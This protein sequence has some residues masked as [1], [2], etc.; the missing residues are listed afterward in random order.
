MC[1]NLPCRYAGWC[2]IELYAS[3]RDFL[4][5]PISFLH[6][7]DGAEVIHRAASPYLFLFYNCL[8]VAKARAR[9]RDL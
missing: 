2:R 4:Q 7:L 1:N 6:A 9:A 3:T 8:L 5:E